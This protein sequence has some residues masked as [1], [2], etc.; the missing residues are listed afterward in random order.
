MKKADS[1]SFDP[2]ESKEEKQK[3]EKKIK[4]WKFLAIILFFF[5]VLIFICYVLP[6]LEWIIE[7]SDELG[8]I[9]KKLGL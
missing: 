1:I 2:M 3:R 7:A 4:D 6:I 8:I 5:A 9:F